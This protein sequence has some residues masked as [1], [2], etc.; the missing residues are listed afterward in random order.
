MFH[1]A[2]SPVSKEALSLCFE[3]L[4]ARPVARQVGAETEGFCIGATFLA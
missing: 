3:R 1:L 2:A 4:S